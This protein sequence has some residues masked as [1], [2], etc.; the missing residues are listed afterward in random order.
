MIRNKFVAILFS[1]FAFAGCLS[2]EDTFTL[3]I[4][5]KEGNFVGHGENIFLLNQDNSAPSFSLLNAGN[6]FVS[7]DCDLNPHLKN[8]E[9]QFRTEHS[10]PFEERLYQYAEGYDS[11]PPLPSV[12]V[13]SSNRVAGRS[14]GSFKVHEISYD[15]EGKVKS[16]AIDFVQLDYTGIGYG[17]IPGFTYGA[18]RYHSS[19]PIDKNELEMLPIEFKPEPSLEGKAYAGYIDGRESG[20]IGRWKEFKITDETGSFSITKD[21]WNPISEDCWNHF[22][23]N[24][25]A[26]FERSWRFYFAAPE[27]EILQPGIYTNASRDSI[28]Y[29][30]RTEPSIDFARYSSGASVLNATFEILEIEY[31]S[32]GRIEKLAIDFHAQLPREESLKASLRYNSEI[33]I[34]YDI[35]LPLV[36]QPPFQI[37][38]S[39]SLE[40]VETAIYINSSPGEYVG[41]GKEYKFTEKEGDISVEGGMIKFHGPKSYYWQFSFNDLSL[42]RH[43]ITEEGNCLIGAESRGCW[44]VGTYEVL[45]NEYGPDGISK[46]AIDFNFSSKYQR[47]LRLVGAIRYHS[48]IPINVN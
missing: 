27:G 48:K 36:D 45:E 2:G 11:P 14:I 41:Q 19:I 33:P 18:L 25:Q 23:L 38:E 40:G 5:S 10:K 28:F 46:L 4:D 17:Y 22:N 30:K 29:W 34:T 21:F 3:Y 37:P 9:L 44:C 43:E 13:S 6:I 16:L 20:Y 24:Y 1:F 12:S 32:E 26:G 8:W 42:G 39:E 47:D 15:E 7:V 35:Q 31:D